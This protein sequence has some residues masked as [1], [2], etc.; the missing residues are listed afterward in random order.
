MEQNP[1]PIIFKTVV[2]LTAS[3]G[4]AALVIAMVPVI[5]TT[6]GSTPFLEPL[7]NTLTYLF[8]TGVGV[9]FGMIGTR[10]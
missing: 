8:S 3:C 7:F 2:S 5:I 1:F 4:V 6:A 10:A 9:I